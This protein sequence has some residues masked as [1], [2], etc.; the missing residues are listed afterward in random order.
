MV[1]PV[2]SALPQN[3]Y[4]PKPKNNLIS[5]PRGMIEVL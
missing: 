4:P 3:N 1:F 5:A 2:I